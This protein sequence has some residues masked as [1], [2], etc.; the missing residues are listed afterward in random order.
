MCLSVETKCQLW[1][2]ARGGGA[3]QLAE[4]GLLGESPATQ[5][6]QVRGSPTPDT[7]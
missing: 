5:D 3:A 7:N 4:S 6:S 2:E 1:G